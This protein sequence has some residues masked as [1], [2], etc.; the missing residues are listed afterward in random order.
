MYIMDLLRYWII[1]YEGVYQD[2]KEDIGNYSPD[3]KL[4]GT[5][6]GIS[7]AFLCR[8][9]PY[10][11]SKYHINKITVEDAVCLV[12]EYISE[13]RPI[14]SMDTTF[15]KV[16]VMYAM[17]YGIEVADYFV[18]CYYGL[19][20]SA[21]NAIKI[22]TEKGT[23]KALSKYLVNTMENMINNYSCLDK[24]IFCNSWRRKFYEIVNTWGL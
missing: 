22:Y 4:I 23:S 16:Y 2:Y 12:A 14:N 1:K 10:M 18:C 21:E 7:A 5:Q 6:Y 20:P 13:R 15:L 19:P 11:C 17:Y 3:G 9:K 8:Y 24:P